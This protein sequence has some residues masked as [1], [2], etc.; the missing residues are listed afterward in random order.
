[1]PLVSIKL[2]VL[3]QKEHLKILLQFIITPFAA[4]ST[5]ETEIVK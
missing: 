3:D 4:K 5:H 1:M 2:N